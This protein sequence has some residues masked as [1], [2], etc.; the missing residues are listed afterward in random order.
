MAFAVLVELL[1][2]HLADAV[3]RLQYDLVQTFGGRV[4]GEDSDGRKVAGRRR[5]GRHA[6]E[7]RLPEPI[8][9]QLLAERLP[10]QKVPAAGRLPVRQ[11]R[12]QR[13]QTVRFR[14]VEA[15]R[16]RLG[17]GRQ[18]VVRARLRMQLGQLVGRLRLFI[19][20]VK[21]ATDQ[22]LSSC[23]LTALGKR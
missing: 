10:Q 16:L 2:T 4:V 11:E 9:R 18:D 14:L 1:E 8:L 13:L 23:N 7:R 12:L 19:E 21:S 22:R 6:H 20:R 17:L 5:R 3:R 15:A